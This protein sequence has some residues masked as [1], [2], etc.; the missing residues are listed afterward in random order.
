MTEG[1]AFGLFEDDSPVVPLVNPLGGRPQGSTLEASRKHK[2]AKEDLMD[3]AA[4]AYYERKVA[5]DG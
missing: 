3:S 5:A 2:E 4:K 1:I